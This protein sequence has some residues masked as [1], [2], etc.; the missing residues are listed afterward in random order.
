[1]EP[2]PNLDGTNCNTVRYNSNRA[3]MNYVDVPKDFLK[4]HKFVT[5]VADTMFVDSTPLVIAMSRGIK[6]VTF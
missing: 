6:L 2:V 1:M 3:V 4:L 5:L